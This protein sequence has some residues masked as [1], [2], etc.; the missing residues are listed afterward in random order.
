M[1]KK[2]HYEVRVSIG[3]GLSMI[4]DKFSCLLS[5]KAYMNK[6]NKNGASCYVLKV[7]KEVVAR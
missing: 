2:V 6:R 5:A 7:T 4:D 1:K 3:D